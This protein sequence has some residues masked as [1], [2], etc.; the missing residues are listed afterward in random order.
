MNPAEKHIVELMA[1]KYIIDL[2]DTMAYEQETEGRVSDILLWEYRRVRE[3]QEK[4][5]E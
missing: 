1:E 4:I 5:H 3:Q 2:M